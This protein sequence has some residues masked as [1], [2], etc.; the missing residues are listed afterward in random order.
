MTP[1]CP[2]RRNLL[3]ALFA[4]AMALALAQ[5]TRHV[6]P[7]ALM[8]RAEKI[9]LL[10]YGF[11]AIAALLDCRRSRQSAPPFPCVSF[12]PTRARI[13]PYVAREHNQR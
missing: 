3:T 1:F 8:S 12:H 4:L 10:T 2:S 7:V 9:H 11:A 6:L 5:W 13:R